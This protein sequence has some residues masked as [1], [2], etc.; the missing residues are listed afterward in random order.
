[1][2]NNDNTVE[3]ESITEDL[4]IDDDTGEPEGS[5][6]LGLGWRIIIGV[7]AIVIVGILAYPFIQERINDNSQALPTAPVQ[8]QAAIAGSKATV[9][10]NPDSAEA[11]FELGNA[12][13]Q[14]GQWPL[15]VDAYQKAIE[16]NPNFQAAYANLGATYYQQL[17][18]DLAASQ[19]EKAL[20]LDADDG[21]SAYNLGAIYLQQALSQGEQPDTELLDKAIFQIEKALQITPELIEPHFSLGVAYM[22]SNRRAEAIAELETFLS[23][24]TNPESQAR[25]DAE[26]YLEFLRG[27]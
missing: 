6:S 24:D 8:E 20:E 1:M 14:E 7:V 17:Q 4:I 22:A 10:A 27:Q 21:E 13:Y 16:L 19:Y 23:L 11:Q 5:K 18:F 12:Y 15:A 2:E 9:Q 25:Q 26:R 3:N